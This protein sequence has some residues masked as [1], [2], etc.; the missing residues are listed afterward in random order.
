[1]IEKE[2]I[3]KK[4]PF[5]T[6]YDSVGTEI[7]EGHTLEDVQNDTL[8]EKMNELEQKALM[9]ILGGNLVKCQTCNTESISMK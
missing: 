6:L 2:Y 7:G 9:G 3:S 8:E 5:L 1:M 4:V